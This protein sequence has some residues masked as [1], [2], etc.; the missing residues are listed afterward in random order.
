MGGVGRSSRPVPGAVVLSRLPSLSG[1]RD[2]IAGAAGTKS[3]AVILMYHR[4]ARV[5]ADPWRIG[6]EPDRFSDHL[7]VIHRHFRP[8]RLLDLVEALQRGSVPPRAVVLTF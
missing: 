8:L 6:V 5:A 2:R 7:D 4:I 1:I 3:S